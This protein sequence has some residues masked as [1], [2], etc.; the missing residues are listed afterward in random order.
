MASLNRELQLKRKPVTETL[1][2]LDRLPMI[3][4]ITLEIKVVLL[5][6]M[7]C[8][9]HVVTPPGSVYTV[10]QC[11]LFLGCTKAGG[12]A[13]QHVGYGTDYCLAESLYV[14]LKHF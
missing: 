2:K 8:L 3:P 10:Y 14:Y 9:V 6:V 11:T 7:C 13:E 4:S 1:G 12:L 5:R